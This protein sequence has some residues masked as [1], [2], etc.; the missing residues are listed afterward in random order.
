[1]INP[2][3]EFINLVYNRPDSQLED[4]HMAD[5]EKKI[6][7][8]EEVPILTD[9]RVF[10]LGNRIVPMSMIPTLWKQKTGFNYDRSA[11]LHARLEGRIVPMG[12][13]KN[14][15]YFWTHEV[16][17]ATPPS[18]QKKRGRRET[19]NASES[20]IIHQNDIDNSS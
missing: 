2:S 9:E 5:S 14:R 1:M 11:P 10:S 15:L 6:I 12:K 4:G 18:H 3:L 7:P 20:K 17:A 16:E 8:L 13:N 19:M